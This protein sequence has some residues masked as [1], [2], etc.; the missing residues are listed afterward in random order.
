MCQRQRVVTGG[1]LLFR[2]L[3]TVS[4]P[5]LGFNEE[6]A[7]NYNRNAD[8]AIRIFNT[9]LVDYFNQCNRVNENNFCWFGLM[10]DLG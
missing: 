10:H 2:P 7:K 6:L 8:L 5:A 3:F 4:V 1:S 9:F